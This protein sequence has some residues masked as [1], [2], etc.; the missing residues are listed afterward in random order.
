MAEIVNDPRI[1][2]VELTKHGYGSGDYLSWLYKGK[3]YWCQGEFYVDKSGVLHHTF[4]TPDTEE[5]IEILVQYS[6][7]D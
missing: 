1:E 4:I 3:S 6:T 2:D 7:W 5:E